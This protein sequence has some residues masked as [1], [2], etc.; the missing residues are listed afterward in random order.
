MTSP[1]QVDD[2]ISRTYVG[3]RLGM[4]VLAVLLFAGVAVEAAAF[5]G[6]LQGSISAYYYTPARSVLV[7]ALCA[8]GACLVIYRGNTTAENALLNVA[9]FLVALVGFVPTAF[10]AD[11]LGCPALN[12]VDKDAAVL[13]G[14]LAL[15][16]AG[17]VALLVGAVQS[18]LSGLRAARSSRWSFGAIA[19]LLAVVLAAFVGD[20]AWFLRWAHGIAAGLFFAL[21]L[22]VIHLN[23]SATAGRTRVLYRLFFAGP[24]VVGAVLTAA[25]LLDPG[26]RTYLLWL[27]AVGI[28]GFGGFWVV[29]TAE[30]GGAVRRVQESGPDTVPPAVTNV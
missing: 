15:V 10:G 25:R 24:I 23:A 2:A 4:V 12:P 13:N 29:Q 30:L 28:A 21:V 17:V 9:G 7:S 1:A 16:A 19:L 14:V 11:P 3:L 8:I 20:R 5:G 6:C 27:E 22:A 18:R 26:F